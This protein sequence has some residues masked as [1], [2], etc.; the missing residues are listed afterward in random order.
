MKIDSEKVLTMCAVLIGL[1]GTIISNKKE[2]I[3]LNNM[4]E[5]VKKEVLEEIS[6]QE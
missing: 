6:K 2:E 4:K 5:E 3:M 1:M